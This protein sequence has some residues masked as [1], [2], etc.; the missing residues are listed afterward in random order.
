[1]RQEAS[2]DAD[3][4]YDQLVHFEAPNARVS[5]HQASTAIT[6]TATATIAPATAATAGI[7]RPG[8]VTTR[9]G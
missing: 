3:P 1:M 6:P 7:R 9:E 4:A 5:D 8:A 2:L